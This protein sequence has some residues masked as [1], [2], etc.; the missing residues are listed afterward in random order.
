MEPNKLEKQIREKLNNRKIKPS[1]AAWDRLDAMLSVAEIKTK[2]RSF[3]WIYIAASL[4]VLLTTGLFFFNQKNADTNANTGVAITKEI[5][6][7]SVKSNVEKGIANP[8]NVQDKQP[9][10][11]VVSELKNNHQKSQSSFK[12]I[13]QKTTSNPIIK[14]DK[15]IEN[16]NNEVIAQKEFS[17]SET[18]KELVVSKPINVD[19]L[20]ASPQLNTKIKTVSIKVNASNLLSQVDGELDQTFRQKV[21]NQIS[22]NYQEVKVALANRNQE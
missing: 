6:S 12:S 17:K 19:E 4:L 10:V 1:E 14:N 13:N 16:Q 15:E 21:I 22:K 3:S 2:K 7:D 5:S 11:Q 20:L 8:T 18:K 9:L